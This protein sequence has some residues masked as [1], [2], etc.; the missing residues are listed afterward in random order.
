MIS[1]FISGFF[2]SSKEPPPPDLVLKT[3]AFC[4]RK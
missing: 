1:M 3:R 4:K 2:G